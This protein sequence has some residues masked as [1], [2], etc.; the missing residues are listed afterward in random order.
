MYDLFDFIFLLSIDKV[1]GRHREVLAVVLIFMMV[2]R[3]KHGRL[4]GSS[5][6]SVGCYDLSFLFFLQ[7]SSNDS[8]SPWTNFSSS[9]ADALCLNPASIALCHAWLVSLFYLLTDVLLLHVQHIVQPTSL[10]LHGPLTLYIRLSFSATNTA[11][12]V[13]RVSMYI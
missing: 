8:H 4:G 6:S 13:R 10:L 5:R 2:I 3:E 12:S 1:R 11:W 9:F 7:R